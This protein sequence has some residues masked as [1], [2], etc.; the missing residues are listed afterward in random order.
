MA[1]RR[2]WDP[3]AAKKA[4]AKT[5]KPV[6]RTTVPAFPTDPI[7]PPSQPKL[8]GFTTPEL[9]EMEGAIEEFKTVADRVKDQKKELQKEHDQAET[10][11]IAVMRKYGRQS[12]VIG[13]YSVQIEDTTKAKV[14]GVPKLKESKKEDDDTKVEISSGGR[15]VTLTP[16]QMVNVAESFK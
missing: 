8:E 13:G 4:K 3:P 1:N 12:I 6:K 15:S 16:E 5:F 9:E 14:K 11:L 7:R 10:A 2:K